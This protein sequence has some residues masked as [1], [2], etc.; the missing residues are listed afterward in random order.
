MSYS[1]NDNA[2]MLTTLL[3][4]A[5]AIVSTYFDMF[6]NPNP[7][8]VTLEQYD[9]DGQIQTYT[10]PNMAKYKLLFT[11]GYINPEGNVESKAGGVYL[12]IVTMTPYVKTS[13]DD[14]TTGGTLGWTQ[15][16][17]PRELLAHDT[18]PEAHL[19]WIA[20]IH[21]SKTEYFNVA[22]AFED[23]HAVQR[24]YIGLLES[25]KTA[26]KRDIVSAINDLQ[27]QVDTIVQ[28]SDVFDI[29]GTYAD[30]ERYDTSVVPPND[31]IKVLQD[32]TYEPTPGQPQP[33]A[34]TYYRCIKYLVVQTY[35]ELLA[36]PTATLPNGIVFQVSRDETH[37][38]ETTYYKCVK[39]GQTFIEW[40]RM[41]D[42]PHNPADYLFIKWEFVGAE[43]PYY[44][45]TESDNRFIHLCK[46]TPIEYPTETIRGVKIFNNDNNSSID[47]CTTFYRDQNDQASYIK[48]TNKNKPT[49]GYLGVD[50]NDHPTYLQS[51]GNN[52][53][54][55]VRMPANGSSIVGSTYLPVYIT[56]DGITTAVTVCHNT[57]IGPLNWKTSPDTNGQR[58]TTTSSIGN[59]DG[60]YI[61]GSSNLR[62]CT[63]GTNNEIV[64]TLNAQTI[65]GVKTFTGA[66]NTFK[67]ADY[68]AGLTI[69][70][71]GA[72][73]PAIRFTNN[74]GVRGYLGVSPAQIPIFS[75]DTTNIQNLLRSGTY[76]T[77]VGDTYLP[78]Y[79][80]TNGVVQ[81]VTVLNNTSFGALGWTDN[82]TGQKLT[83]QN[84]IAYWDGRYISSTSGA[85]SNLKY[86]N[87]AT[88]NEIVGTLNAQT[89]TGHKT[90]ERTSTAN[91]GISIKS[92]ENTF[93]MI[94]FSNVTNGI[95][96]YLGVNSSDKIPFFDSYV[97]GSLEKHYLVHMPAPVN[98]QYIP[99]GSTTLPV[100]LDAKGEPHTI[101]SY[102]GTSARAIADADGNVIKDY[103]Y[104]IGT[105]IVGKDID[106]NTLTNV[107][108]YKVQVAD[109]FLTDKNAP[110]ESYSYGLLR[111]SRIKVG[112]DTENRILQEY[113]PHQPYGNGGH[114]VIWTRMFNSSEWQAWRA[115]EDKT[116][117]VTITDSQTI[118]GVKTFSATPVITSG[119]LNLNNSGDVSIQK[120]GTNFLRKS[121]ANDVILSSTGSNGIYFR[122][123]GDN[124]TTGQAYLATDGNLTAV[125]F[126]GPL[127]GNAS[128]ATTLQTARNINGTS[129]NGSAD[130][131]TANWGTARNI[132]I[133]DS[134]GTNTGT[135]T[136]V[137]GSQA[138]T[139][140]L[141]STIKASLTGT[142]D[143]AKRVNLVRARDSISD[144]N[145][146]RTTKK[147]YFDELNQSATNS[148]TAH[149]YNY[150][151]IGSDDSA[152]GTQLALGMTKTDLFYRNFDHS[153]W[154]A[155][156]QILKNNTANTAT[157][158]T[159]LPVYIDSNGVAQACGTS[160]A[161]SVTGSSA[162]CTGNANTATTLQTTR[163]INGTNFN[164]SANITTA[165][166][167]T[168]RNIGI[169]NSDGTGTA[170]TVSVNG[171][172]NVNL[173][174]PATIKASI[175]GDVTG[176]VTG[177]LTG[178]VTGNAD[179]AT[180][181]QT[182]RKINGTDFNGSADIT[183]ANWG[184]ARNISIAD[185]DSTNTGTA[186][187]VN[188]SQAYTLKLPSTIKASLTGNASTA[189]TLQTTRTING[190]NFNGSAN[191][192]TANWGT[193]RAIGIINSDGTGT[194]VTVNVNG[195]GDVNLKLPATIKASITGDV[196]GNAST[197]STLK[198]SRNING[199]PFNGSADITTASWGTSRDITISD[200]DGT[201]T[202]TAVAVDGS[203]NK[204]LK[205]PSTIKASIT[206]NCSGSSG[207]CTGNAASATT[208][209]KVNKTAGATPWDAVYVKGQNDYLRIR[210][211]ESTGNS[212]WAEIATADDGNE[213]IYVRQYTGVFSNIARTLTLL[214]GSGNTSIPGTL[215]APKATLLSSDF[216]NLEV[217]RN[218]ASS[219]SAIKFSNTTET[220]GYIGMS[221]GKIP[222]QW[223]GSD[224][225]KW[226][227]LLRAPQNQTTAV[228]GPSVPCYID[229]NGI[230]QACTSIS[231]TIDGT[232]DS[233]NKDGSGNVITDTYQPKSTAV[234]HTA[235]TAVG[236]TSQPCYIKDGGVATACGFT[237]LTNVPA[238]AVFSDTKNTA[239]STDTSSKIF[240]VGTNTQTTSSQSYSHD[241]V[242]VDVN[243]RVNSAAPASDANDTT[244]AT[245]K[246]VKD[247]GYRTSDSDTKNTA[248]STD[249]SS[250]IF[251]VGAPT[252]A[253][254][255]QTYSHDTV[256]V[257][258]NGRVNS[259]AP[260]N[261]AN[262]TTVATTAWVKG[263]GYQTTDTKN[264]AGS[265]DTSSKIFL[266]GAQSQAANPQT[267]SHDTAFVDTSG[268]LNSANPAASTSSTVVAT[269]KWVTDKGYLTSVPNIAS[270]K[271]TAM[272]GYSKPSS[273]S[274]IV[275]TDSLN[276]A[277]GK[278]EKALDG[279]SGTDVNVTNTLNNTAKA[280]VTGTTSSTT[281]TGTQVFDN[282][283]YLTTTAGKFNATT[284][285]VGAENVAMVYN[286]TTQAL[287][288]NFA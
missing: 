52:W 148:P 116:R 241:T 19:E 44:T 143:D 154:S 243:G 137:N 76:N 159:T 80:G 33:G 170:V 155:W 151:T 66:N 103:Y 59:W 40:E 251:L 107:G 67:H 126:T 51:N 270:N 134:D 221:S 133:S 185:S 206:G 3:V 8:D 20:R 144:A 198:T 210:F 255:P 114:G 212:G 48:F 246:W 9:S 17:T 132:S 18:D 163:T 220:T 93:P 35:A 36:R 200:S 201:N 119:H 91:G 271:V 157:G 273:T 282:G 285:S 260:A 197:A 28:S 97:N 55:I 63:G 176:D 87:G 219:D 258:T 180:T 7:V 1:E 161:V 142:A 95:L 47:G 21:G 115:I 204:T 230:A 77:A 181:L 122:P 58:L 279:K 192:T 120:Q 235:S 50:I 153:T 111:V 79:A 81:T 229:A 123:N 196:T 232:V 38:N 172:G 179:T 127:V 88:N 263:R 102:E 214:D 135:A 208:A 24:K 254:N 141:P 171:S 226:Y 165:N 118:S 183:T 245:T 42:G 253:A 96:G 46:E 75:V 193:Q 14:S 94:G 110:T 27:D 30:L 174:L 130:I 257:D 224:T 146:L 2:I 223:L 83:T 128:T 84:S 158:S 249:T 100:Y 177:N 274:A 277:I 86:C 225:S 178:N 167:G 268:Q 32:E 218:S 57:S 90:F 99:V 222:R 39:D 281:N 187:S 5:E 156:Q 150:M 82:T 136:S 175:T 194:A 73:S 237:V 278:L 65:S 173:K 188:G 98:S 205:L 215:S 160:L 125:K 22:S 259:A 240:L 152:Y 217:K 78:I 209:E 72:G 190:T 60:Q 288:F 256:F 54:R 53:N 207:S 71:D 41:S 101:T 244:V 227:R 139:L 250:K 104:P 164:G 186:T 121:S 239:G 12:D 264:T 15:I 287:E 266:I 49:L 272:T 85:N 248:G 211:D 236:S 149:F 269:T 34:T 276:T 31:I 145:N 69:K 238:N 109:G 56:A 108:I 216:G 23:E 283:V 68:G 284:L 64:G 234:T 26:N 189:T 195:S 105:V 202:G 89:I 184:T 242:F 247:Q 199:T 267:Y 162:S 113:F 280:Y 112:L 62:Y 286:S 43:G 129:F 166:W 74:D 4:N 228:G 233:A 138:Y 45:K 213:P 231:V 25:L 106:W 6:F 11:R 61:A 70:R 261:D 147:V 203:A 117:N 252:Q 140:K 16:L 168:A 10:V 265:T 169:V 182:T 92:Y 262:D 191:I 124:N 131:T 13:E 275:A 29:V 37:N